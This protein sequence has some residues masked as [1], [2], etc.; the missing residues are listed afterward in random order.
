VKLLEAGAV[1]GV[2]RG[3]KE[4]GPRALG[5]RSIIGDPRSP[6]MQTKM[7]L[8]IKFRE[9][10][11]PFA[12]AVL[13]E[14]A[15]DWFALEQESPYML[16]VAQVND[17]HL[18]PPPAGEPARGIARLKVPRST[19]QAVTHVDN[20]ARVQ[21]V[22]AQ[23]NP[24][25]HS[26]LAAFKAKTGC[27]VLVNTSFN[28]RGEPIVCGAEDALRCFMNTDMDALVIEN[29]LLLKPDQPKSADREKYL[30][31]FALD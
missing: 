9:G 19:I 20:S 22:S 13:E 21:T 23:D 5:S 27:P 24:F 17:E 25:F 2:V 28:V 7:N 30:K 26:L 11:R 1:I 4:L 29:F 18:I 12:P 10:F 31:E 6:D 14:E 15:K 3:R 16:L 8:K